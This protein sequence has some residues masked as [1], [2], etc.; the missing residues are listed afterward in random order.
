M[1]ILRFSKLT[2]ISNLNRV[3][4]ILQFVDLRAVYLNL[5]HT[6]AIK[7]SMSTYIYFC[8]QGYRSLHLYLQCRGADK[9]KNFCGN[10]SWTTEKVV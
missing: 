1:K 2:I 8:S 4:T 7:R 6:T 5:Q 10:V 3:T 9:T